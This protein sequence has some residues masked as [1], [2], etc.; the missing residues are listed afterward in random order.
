MSEHPVG[1][2]L[3]LGAMLIE[4]CFEVGGGPTGGGFRHRGA[5]LAPAQGGRSPCLNRYL[6][7]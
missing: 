6:D 4:L 5:T 7:A 1:M 3:E 2:G